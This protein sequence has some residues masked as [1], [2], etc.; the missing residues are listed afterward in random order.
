MNGGWLF[1]RLCLGMIFG[2]VVAMTLHWKS[3]RSTRFDFEPNKP[4]YT[5]YFPYWLLPAYL[6]LLFLLLPVV[7]G[8]WG[9]NVLFGILF[10][11][12][13]QMALYD[14]LMLLL[15]PL[16][17]RFIR[18][19][20][21]VFLWMLPNYLYLTHQTMLQPSR[22][23]AVLAIPG[24]L[25]LAVCFIWLAGFVGVL[26]WNIFSHLRFRRR[27][28]KDAKPLTEPA[29]ARL[30]EE[31]RQWAGQPRRRCPLLVSPQVTSP[32]S[33]GLFSS[34]IQ[35]VLPERHYTQEELTLILRHELIHIGRGD[36]SAKFFFAFCSALCWFN[37]L[38]WA[39]MGRGAEELELSCDQEVLEWSSEEDRQ[40]YARLLLTTAGEQAGFTTCL[41]ASASS[42]RYRLRHVLHPIQR[43]VWGSVSGLAVFAL[44]LSGG[45]V[46]LAYGAGTGRE[47]L[48]SNGDQEI[49]YLSEIYR[50]H[51]G[52]YGSACQITDQE[53]LLDYLAGL[54][55]QIVTGPYFYESTGEELWLTCHLDGDN[56]FRLVLQDTMVY[57][58]PIHQLYQ[59]RSY[60]VAGG[61]NWGYLE[62]LLAA[63]AH[64]V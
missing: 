27:I 17:R 18:P 38:V 34:T 2:V 4:R 10:Q 28:L 8:P 62:S 11:V 21:C 64:G 23:M 60:Q 39:A 59:P 26:G 48:L 51:D 19:Q 36:S 1:R 7:M 55:L 41:S 30:W 16:L 42:L 25:M 54:E 33:I 14:G 12:F 50:F 3:E 57:A 56:S 6:L 22:P 63:E 40:E 24:P 53:A 35:V 29:A 49:S 61:V 43:N 52:E 13:L 46:S 31:L 47:L 44:I 5:P 20:T 9:G 45:F 15:L 58:Y 32:L 37:P